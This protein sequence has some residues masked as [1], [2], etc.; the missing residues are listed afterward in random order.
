MHNDFRMNRRGFLKQTG[1]A[2]TAAGLCALPFSRM[3]HAAGGS[4]V[5]SGFGGSY[6]ESIRTAVL[7]PFAAANGVDLAVTTGASDVAKITTMVKSG[8]VQWD[9]VDAQGTTLSQFIQAGL[10]EKLDPAIV[11]A[12]DIVLTDLVTPY[13][14]P[15]YQFSLNIYWNADAVQGTPQ[16][17]ADVWDVEKFPGKRGFSLLPWFSLEAALLAD[18]VP[19]DKLYPLDVD[20]AFAALD[21]I[22]PHAV[23]GAGDN[24]ISAQEVVI[25]IGNLARLKKI[26]SAGVNIKYSWEQA[27]IDVQQLVLLKGAPNP[28]NG[29]GAIAYSLQAEPQRQVL[30]KLGYTPTLKSALA[31]ISPEKAKDL[32]GTEATLKNSFYLNSSWWGENGA[33]VGRRW[34]DWL[35]T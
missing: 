3:A 20:R 24:A 35:A 30:E 26:Q 33:S 2:V 25:G 31:E 13:S 12:D 19:M 15:W 6:E 22:K 14:V 23:F 9:L 11:K 16:S 7:E 27:I 17:W 32:A 8:R 28:V 10:L 18:G 34:Q 21:R 5:Y 1:L 4:L 29:Q